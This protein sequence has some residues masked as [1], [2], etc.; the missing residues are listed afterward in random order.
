MQDEGDVLVSPP[1]QLSINL[2][3]ESYTAEGGSEIPAYATIEHVSLLNLDAYDLVITLPIKDPQLVTV[4]GN[5][6]AHF[7]NGTTVVFSK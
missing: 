7:S 2:T 1:A 3:L 5:A 4:S 6:T